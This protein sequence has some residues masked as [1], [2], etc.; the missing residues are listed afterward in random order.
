VDVVPSP[1]TLG[2]PRSELHAAGPIQQRINT[3]IYNRL[4]ATDFGAFRTIT[5]TGVKLRAAD[6]SVTAPFDV[7]ADRLLASENDAAKIGV[8]PESTLG[9]YLAAV[10]ADVRHLAAITQTPR[11]FL[12]GEMINLSGDAIKAAEAGL[13][14]KIERRAAHIGEAWEEVARL[15]LGFVGSPGAVNY[16]GQVIWRDFETRSEAVT[17]DALTKMAALGVPRD[18]LWARW[19]ATP[20]DIEAWKTMEPVD[21]GGPQQPT[22][23]GVST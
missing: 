4:V 10:E 19:G 16:A 18:V 22:T 12:L 1:R 5:A 3:T 23:Q 9:G 8:I 13:V 17:V 7:G 21:A 2:P 15:A 14:A 11:T 6:G 20:A